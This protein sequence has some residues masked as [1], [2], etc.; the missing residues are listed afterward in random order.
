MSKCEICGSKPACAH[1]IPGPPRQHW[2]KDCRAEGR[3]GKPL[4]A[5]YPGPRC[6]RHHQAEKRR[7]RQA[8]AANRRQ[9]AYGL[10]DTAYKV[11]L[12]TQDYQCA[13]CQRP[14]PARGR[15]LAV[16]H[17]HACCPGKTSCGYCIRGLLCWTCNK[18][19][20]HINDDPDVAQGLANYLQDPPAT[21]VLLK[22]ESA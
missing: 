14:Q 4:A 22:L 8:A 19:L 1:S 9:A 15:A 5:P 21:L 6:Y 11:L 7:I 13:I 10:T 17:D 3:T 18:F 12:E 2:C 20:Q 16:D